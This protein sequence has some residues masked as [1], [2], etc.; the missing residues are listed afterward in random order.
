MF[1]AIRDSVEPEPGPGADYRGPPQE[2]VYADQTPAPR[3]EGASSAGT[4]L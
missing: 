3:G 1:S 2:D 4:N